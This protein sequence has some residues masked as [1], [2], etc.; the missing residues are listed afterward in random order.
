VRCRELVMGAEGGLWSL[1]IST[2]K[3]R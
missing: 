1:L 2:A 3:H